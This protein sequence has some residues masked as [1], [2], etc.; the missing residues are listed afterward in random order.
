MAE[1]HEAN[2]E[3]TTVAVSNALLLTRN[4]ENYQRW[5]RRR[6]PTRTSAPRAPV[7]ADEQ[8]A[9]FARLAATG[10]IRIHD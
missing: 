9:T 4:P 5:A 8:A 2:S 3:R 1:E 6:T 7:S 10:R